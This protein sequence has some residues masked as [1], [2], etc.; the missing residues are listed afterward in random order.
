MDR[1]GAAGTLPALEGSG[2]GLAAGLPGAGAAAGRIADTFP[3]DGGA[4]TQRREP[5]YPG[6]RGEREL[7]ASARTIWV[8]GELVPWERATVHVLSHSLQRGSLVF[9][10]MSVHETPR[11]A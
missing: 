9:D 8:D 11:G 4:P 1:A 5:P 10:Y 3:R 2:S 6:G 7:D